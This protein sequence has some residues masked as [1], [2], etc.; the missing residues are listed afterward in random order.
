MF[1]LLLLLYKLYGCKWFEKC[2]DIFVFYRVLAVWCWQPQPTVWIDNFLYLN[3]GGSGSDVCVEALQ[4]LDGLQWVDWIYWTLVE[5]WMDILSYIMC[6]IFIF[7][8]LVP[9]LNWLSW[10]HISFLI[11]HSFDEFYLLLLVQ[12]FQKMYL[13]EINCN[14]WMYVWIR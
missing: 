13:C 6:K 9:N 12:L 14:V 4:P 8:L 1:V 7:M 3:H 11:P 2:T 10:K 5:I